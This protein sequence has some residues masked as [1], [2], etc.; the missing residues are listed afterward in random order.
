MA[1]SLSDAEL[2]RVLSVNDA[3]AARLL[4]VAVALGWSRPQPGR[5]GAR[6]RATCGAVSTL[7]EP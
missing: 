1:V 6:A 3:M 7:P 4:P 2:G 5:S